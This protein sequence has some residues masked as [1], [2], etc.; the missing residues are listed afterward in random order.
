[1]YNSI[2]MSSSLN[3]RLV[4]SAVIQ[5]RRSN[6]EKEILGQTEDNLNNNWRWPLHLLPVIP[7]PTLPSCLQRRETANAAHAHRCLNVDRPPSLGCAGTVSLRWLSDTPVCQKKP[8]RFM[9]IIRRRPV[10]CL[11]KFVLRFSSCSMLWEDNL[12]V[13]SDTLGASRANLARKLVHANGRLVG[14]LLAYLYL[15]WK[16][17]QY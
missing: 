14:A 11:L 4:C 16:N 5:P 9:N 1:M 15:T 7:E 6:N 12:A 17:W 3:R 13:S 2:E 10:I 8:N